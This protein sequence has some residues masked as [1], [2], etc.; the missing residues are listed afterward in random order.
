MRD[1]PRLVAP[2]VPLITTVLNV[3]VPLCEAECVSAA[4]LPRIRTV[5]V[6]GVRLPRSLCVTLPVAA[7]QRLGRSPPQRREEGGRAPRQRK[8]Q[9]QRRLKLVVGDTRSYLIAGALLVV[10]T[11]GGVG[12]I[13][14]R[15]VDTIHLQKQK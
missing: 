10:G 7:R 15:R 11:M 5:G 14:C 4:P 3:S 9:R 2:P 6:S 12:A 13:V 1:I 8:R